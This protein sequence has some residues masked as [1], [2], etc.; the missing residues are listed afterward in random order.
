MHWADA[1]MGGDRRE[2]RVGEEERDIAVLLEEAARGGGGD[3]WRRRRWVEEAA[4]RRGG[5]ESPASPGIP[6]MRGRPLVRRRL[7]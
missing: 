5:L 7:V 2:G 4:A 1:H 3:P 6:T